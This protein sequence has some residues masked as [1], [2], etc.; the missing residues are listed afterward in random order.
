MLMVI[1]M[2]DNQTPTG[3]KLPVDDISD[4]ELEAIA[5]GMLRDVL[6]RKAA[7]QKTLETQLAKAMADA[8]AHF[9]PVQ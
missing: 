9:H 5:E 7:A 3:Q 8:K 4:E 1:T 2:T 6:A